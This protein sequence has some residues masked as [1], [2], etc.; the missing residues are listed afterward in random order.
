MADQPIKHLLIGTAG[1]VDHGKTALIREL[2]GVDTDRLEEEHE[3]GISIVLGFASYQPRGDLKTQVGIIDVPGHERFI[4]TMVAGAT[5]VDVALFVV[6]CDEG[7]KPQTIEHLEILSLLGVDHGVIALT[8]MDL[9]DDPE[10]AELVAEE[11][12]DVVAPTF[13][14]DAPIIPVSA[15]TGQGLDELRDT[16]EEVLSTI[17]E[18]MPGTFFRL[19]IDRS[20][21]IKGIGTVVTGSV[22]SGIVKVGDPLEIQPAGLST[23]IRDIQQHGK[24]APE[25]SPGTRTAVALHSVSVDKASPGSWLITPRSLS[26][27]RTVDL[28]IQ[29]LASAPGPLKH[30]QRVRIHHGTKET[31]GRLRVLG[32][33]VLL[34]GEEGFAQLHLEEPLVAA[35]G[36][37]LLLRRYSPMRTIA[38]AMIL[39]IN[40]SRHR[41]SDIR[42][43]DTLEVRAKGDPEEIIS[44]I[45]GGAGLIGVTVEEASRRSSMPEEEIVK[46]TGSMGLRLVENRLIKISF[47]EEAVGV[48]ISALENAHAQYPL[49]RGLSSEAVASKLGVPSGHAVS[50]A[51]L[52][53]AGENG[54]VERDPP[55]WRKA[56]FRVRFEG[57]YEEVAEAIISAAGERDIHPL[58]TE[59]VEGLGINAASSAGLAAEEVAELLDA[60]IHQGKMVRY[61]GG[62]LLSEMGHGKLVEIL[63]QHFKNSKEL[64]VPEFRDLTGGL[65]RKYVIPIL[66][67]M[68]SK[69]LTVREGDVR[70]AGSALH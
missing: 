64:S 36:D 48:L 63:R 56:G 52:Q 14:S 28:K 33:E 68:D 62:F 51:V 67:Y 3:R 37:R 46:K 24:S 15:V 35:V 6:A 9:V 69:K 8:K 22:W 10:W 5:G 18:R 4:K 41:R 45:V 66:E 17:P 25:T 47:I 7:V 2:T 61:P 12:R 20:F 38:G 34:P 19:P 50:D 31:F 1:H 54:L 57:A 70:V 49:R 29:H 42:I 43:V 58:S 53:Q 27:S 11:V 59:E 55:F 13:L 32:S 44:S 16:L 60:L 26:P 30:N 21:T 23:R 65:T 40:P 39:D